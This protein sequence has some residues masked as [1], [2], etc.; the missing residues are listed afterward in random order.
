MGW[1]L[2][3]RPTPELGALQSA[4]ERHL[5][6]SLQVLAT[7]SVH[8][9]TRTVTARVEGV[10]TAEDLAA[11]TAAYQST[12]GYRLVVEGVG[13][14]DTENN[15]A[16]PVPRE[17]DVASH[18][19]SGVIPLEINLAIPTIRESLEVDGAVV[20]RVGKRGDAVEVTFLTPA[21]GQGCLLRIITSRPTISSCWTSGQR[22][23]TIP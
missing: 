22:V 18:P 15:P 2:E 16:L 21:V 4:V 3:I 17:G 8:V 14:P 1:R 23:L 5:P 11:A 13:L 12:T 7:A 20:Y 19:T 6:S 10:A 9:E